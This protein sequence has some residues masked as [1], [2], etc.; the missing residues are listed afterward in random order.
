MNSINSSV[1]GDDEDNEFTILFGSFKDVVVPLLLDNTFAAHKL[2]TSTA[3]HLKGFPPKAI[4]SKAK[5]L[6]VDDVFLPEARTLVQ[7]R[8]REKEIQDALKPQ[9]DDKK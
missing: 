4:S 2:I 9:K 8:R 6:T 7:D 1:V 5:D 3:A